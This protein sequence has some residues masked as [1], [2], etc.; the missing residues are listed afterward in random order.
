MLLLLMLLQNRIQ[1]AFDALP[2]HKKSK[3]A[4]ADYCGVSPPSVN[5]WFNGKTKSLKGT[6]LIKAAEYLNVREQ[7]LADGTGPKERDDRRSFDANIGPADVGTRRIP[8]LNYVQAGMFTEIGSNF[9]AE[10]MEYLLTDLD[11]S[12]R[13]FALE[14]KGFSMKAPAGSSTDSFSPGDRIIVDCE[15][16][17]RPGDFVVAKNGGNEATF[18]KYRLVKVDDEGREIFELVPLNPDFPTI[19][20]DEQHL[21]IIGTMLEHR[22]SYRR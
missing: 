15:V 16:S 21:E 3:K 22:K 6:S 10:G 4:L 17:P 7:W 2:D 12:S 9:S 8:L 13:A 5:G 20:S 1:T 18:K 14:I 19:R 11:V